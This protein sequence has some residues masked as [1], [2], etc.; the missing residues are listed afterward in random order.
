MGGPSKIASYPPNGQPSLQPGAVARPPQSAPN[1]PVPG[2]EPPAQQPVPAADNGVARA[3]ELV[4]EL[5][6]LLAKAGKSAVKEVDT[7][8]IDSAVKRAKLDKE[9]VARVQ[10]AAKDANATLCALNL[11][12]GRD[13]LRALQMETVVADGK[14]SVVY[15]WNEE[16]PFGKIVKAAIDKQQALSAELMKLCSNPPKKASPGFKSAIMEAMLQC[17]RRASEIQTIVLEIVDLF[18]K[19][20]KI[21][22]MATAERLARRVVDMAGEKAL[23]MHDTGAVIASFKEKLSPINERLDYYYKNQSKVASKDELRTFRRTIDEAKNAIANAARTGVVTVRNPGGSTRAVHVDRKLLDEISKLL[24]EASEKLENLEESAASGY[25]LKLIEKDIPKINIDL[26]QPKFFTKLRAIAARAYVIGADRV[27]PFLDL[28]ETVAK[29]RKGLQNYVDSPSIATRNAVY[30]VMNNLP[31]YSDDIDTIFE[32]GFGSLID[33]VK[34]SLGDE[35]VEGDVELRAAVAKAALLKDK[36]RSS[37]ASQFKNLCWSVRLVMNQHDALL[38]RAKSSDALRTNGALLGVFSGEGSF[39]TLVESRVH[40]YKDGDIDPALDDR[41]VVGSRNLG[42]GAFNTV[43]LVAFKDGSKRVFKPELAGRMASNFTPILEGIASTQEITSIN[44][45]VNRTADALGLDDVM[46]KTTPGVHKGVFGMYMEVA[47]GVEGGKLAA[48]ARGTVGEKDDKGELGAADIKNLPPDQRRIVKGRMMRKLNRLHW[49]D[50]IT[51]QGDR[52]NSN[53]MAQVKPDLSV[54]VKAVDNDSSFSILRTGLTTFRVPDQRVPKYK[55]LIKYY[56]AMY[57]AKSGIAIQNAL[58]DPGFHA[59]KDGTVEIDVSKVKSPIL[60]AAL[61][62]TVGLEVVSVPD[63]IDADLYRK[64]TAL[65]EGEAR[66]S[67]LNEWADRFGRESQ[68]YRCA[69]RRLDEAI[70]RAEAL[71]KQGKVFETEE[72]EKEDVQKQV[73]NGGRPQRIEIAVDGQEP[74]G[75]DSKDYVNRCNGMMANNLYNRDFASWE[76]RA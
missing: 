50:A 59:M 33:A 9:T 30:A 8:A 68:Q 26:L 66:E 2:G 58:N 73:F 44:L 65:K 27:T 45:A 63:E 35:G 32:K 29:I 7:K 20:P 55:T 39:T 3:N 10:K 5:D 69:T 67:L 18:E 19:D 22:D 37:A 46:V 25:S 6:V 31:E 41:N 76:A 16:G 52:H 1:A 70:A 34:D 14:T 57:G 72:W 4:R 13:I 53:Y 47:P 64:L 54:T 17:D 24:G 11:L 74:K 60:I 28:V 61:R 62:K 71:K 49:F 40:G 21:T 51:G 48:G 75:V 42:A 36:E 23:V 43:E 38:S 56:A 12:S 15:G